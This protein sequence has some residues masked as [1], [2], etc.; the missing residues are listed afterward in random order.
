MTRP[1]GGIALILTGTAAALALLYFLRPIPIP[2]VIAFV[3]AVLVNAPV[4]FIHKRMLG[5]PDWAVAFTAALVVVLLAA[6]G[7]Y[8]M[9]QGMVQIVAEGPELADRLDQMV[10]DIGRA[11]RLRQELH[12]NNI[13]GS[14]SVPELAGSV[15]LFWE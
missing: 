2:F 8:V 7:I 6:G 3:F 11:L 13:I 5:A 14:I 12:L 9:A 4:Q 1:V 10:Q 15:L